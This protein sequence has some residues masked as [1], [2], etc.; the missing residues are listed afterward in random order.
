MATLIIWG[1]KDI[2]GSSKNVLSTKQ[3]DL[4]ND[5]IVVMSDFGP[6]GTYILS[7]NILAGCNSGWGMVSTVI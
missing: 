2:L 3:I 4:T 5:P 7:G 1:L 6:Q